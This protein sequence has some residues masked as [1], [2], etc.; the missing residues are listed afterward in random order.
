MAGNIP[1]KNYPKNSMC[2]GKLLLILL[3]PGSEF[4]LK[5]HI[6][7]GFDWLKV[8]RASIYDQYQ[9]LEAKKKI[10]PPGLGQRKREIK[11][12]N[13]ISFLSRP[14]LLLSTDVILPNCGLVLM[15]KLIKYSTTK[16]FL[17][18]ENGLCCIRSHQ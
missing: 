6:F 5:I 15:E 17:M 13:D 12:C 2:Q 14:E 3:T 9:W 18:K 8:H 16:I 7:V 10:D 1:D 4:S 11:K